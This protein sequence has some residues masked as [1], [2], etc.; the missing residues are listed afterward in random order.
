MGNR[1]NHYNQVLT[2]TLGQYVTYL[3]HCMTQD[4]SGQ[5]QGESLVSGYFEQG[6]LGLEI[7]MSRQNQRWG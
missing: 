6:R 3:Q 5:H 2:A 4:L 1:S 7:A